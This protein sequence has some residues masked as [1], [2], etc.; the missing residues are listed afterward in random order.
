MTRNIKGT[1][2]VYEV[3][4]ANVLLGAQIQQL[5]RKLPIN[6]RSKRVHSGKNVHHPEIESKVYSGIKFTVM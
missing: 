6:C 5:I 2:E 4:K 3:T 1:A